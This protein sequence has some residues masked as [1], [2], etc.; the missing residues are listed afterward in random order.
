M[1]TAGPDHSLS[2]VT[3]LVESS[4][5]GLE[6]TRV[7][8]PGPAA[9]L[10]VRVE[11][12][13]LEVITDEPSAEQSTPPSPL[14]D[15]TAAL[16][17][18]VVDSRKQHARAEHRES[19]IDR[20]H[21]ELEQ[22]RRGERRSIMRPILT[23]VCRLRDDLI[24]QADSLPAD[25]DAARASSLLASYA[26]SAEVALADNGVI[27]YQPEP[28]DTFEPRNHRA[29]GKVPSADPALAGRIAGV[30]KSGYRDVETNLTILPAEVIVF[31]AGPTPTLKGASS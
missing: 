28:D 16:E 17:K 25:F 9:E 26:E 2:P 14:D 6:L 12:D 22:L 20:M 29:V 13:A 30:R 31:V 18:L 3:S 23:E 24:R 27:A 5:D 4:A 8:E 19:I 11:P 15:L 1:M 10:E 7:G 21:A